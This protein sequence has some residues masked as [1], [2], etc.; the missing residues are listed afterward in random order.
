M[1]REQP[2]HRKVVNY[3]GIETTIESGV[4]FL[5]CIS[6]TQYI[7]LR[8][9]LAE[10]GFWR[11]I[12][13]KVS[14]I[15]IGGITDA[16]WD[17][18]DM[19]VSE[20]L[21]GDNIV[22]ID[23]LVV[24]LAGI[25][26]AIEASIT[27]NCCGG[28]GSGGAGYRP[29]I[30]GETIPDG[31]IPDGFTTLAEYHNYKCAMAQRLI[32]DMMSDILY[33]GTIDFTLALLDIVGIGAV[34]FVTPIPHDDIIVIVAFA[35]AVLGAGFTMASVVDDI[36]SIYDELTCALVNSYSLSQARINFK[37]EFSGLGWNDVIADFVLSYLTDES[38][39]R[40]FLNS[41]YEDLS[42]I[43]TCPSCWDELITGTGNPYGYVAGELDS[44]KYRVRVC[45]NT[46][47]TV[48]VDMIDGFTYSN[49]T[50]N[51]W[52][53]GYACTADSSSGGPYS[54]DDPPPESPLT[55][56][57]EILVKSSTPFSF[58][59]QAT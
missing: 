28:S 54:Q 22:C 21:G 31:T 41:S 2:N 12:Y 4:N 23:D 56:V 30:G 1:N 29:V 40:L 51:D 52:H 11:S 13:Y 5:L 24:A 32:T 3:E 38:L 46:A 47:K 9:I 14:G 36:N 50:G 20:L 59:I 37:G 55:N 16:E 49:L 10:F 34:A 33:M 27:K 48:T 25:Q 6:E 42:G 44:G 19:V 26:S 57:I 58:R 35:I 18:I 8:S 43:T 53:F 39:S 17:N 15:T 45:Y 7:I